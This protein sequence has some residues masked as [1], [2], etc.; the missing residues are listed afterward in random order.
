[1]EVIYWHSKSSNTT[2]S[3]II[4]E[5]IKNHDYDKFKFFNKNSEKFNIYMPDYATVYENGKEKEKMFVL[6]K[7]NFNL[8]TESRYI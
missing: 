7:K 5:A 4:E 6:S 8:I 1:M 2:I 3:K